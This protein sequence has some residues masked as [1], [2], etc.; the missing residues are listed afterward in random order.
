M[1]NKLIHLHH[2]WNNKA[3]GA[4]ASALKG[5]IIGYS[6]CGAV[7]VGDELTAFLDDTTCPK[8]KQIAE[9]DHGNQMP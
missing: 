3:R 6:I 9:N 7:F 5:L 8:C 2:L 4:G 1:A